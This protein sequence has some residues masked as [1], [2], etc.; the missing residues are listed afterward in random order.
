MK[1]LN[2]EEALYCANVFTN[3][4]GQF[5]R[6]DQYM[7]DQKLSQLEDTVTA[8]L[9]GM[10]PETEIFD[11]F[12]M[13]PEEMNFKVEIPDNKIFDTLLNMTSSHTNMSSV[14]GKGMKI[15]VRET[16]T[17]KVVGFIRLGS[18]VINSGPRNK[19]L[20][21][22]PDLKAFNKTSIMGFVI[23]PTQPFGYNYLGGKLLAAICCSHWVREELN[24]KYDMNL[25][26]F[27]TTSLYGSSK[28]SSQYDGMKPYLRYKGLTMSD[29]IP[30]IHGDAYHNLVNYVE[31]R[32]GT[33]VKQG[34]SSRKLKMTNAIIGLIKRSLTGDELKKF[35]EVIKNAKSLTEK[36]R[37][38]VSNYGIKNYIDIVNGKTNELIKDENYDKFELNN[39]I[40]WWKKKAS[41]RFNN[42]KTENR[43][44]KEL[45]IWTPSAQID[46]IR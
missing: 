43:L 36:K 46:I 29:F 1:N 26:M 38:Y 20:G 33:L 6:I 16:N 19:V 35:N 12:E 10:G 25:V 2:N 28:S 9:P 30:L 13:S 41:N 21:G 5:D 8:S 40:E 39:I 32:V 31:N 45:E 24:K 17:N 37:F 34:A 42:L 3:Y 22:V 18:P 7:R 27:E 14:P 44:R 11:N 23:V 15:M 4:F